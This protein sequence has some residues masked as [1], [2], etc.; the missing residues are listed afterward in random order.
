[1][2][3]IDEIISDDENIAQDFASVV[4]NPNLKVGKKLVNQNLNFI[5][6]FVLRAIKRYKNHPK[7]TERNV[8]R[9]YFS[10]GFAY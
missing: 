3:N 2:I 7:G 1:M 10:F 5:E 4:K 6:N 8:K 9:T